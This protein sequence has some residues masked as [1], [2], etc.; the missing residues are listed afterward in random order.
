M[1]L[2]SESSDTTLH[3]KHPNVKWV[4]LLAGESIFDAM[5]VDKA[6]ERLLLVKFRDFELSSFTNESHAR[7]SS[8][9]NLVGGKDFF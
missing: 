8:E 9:K 2:A 1:G 7:I 5:H 3:V 6:C 4:T